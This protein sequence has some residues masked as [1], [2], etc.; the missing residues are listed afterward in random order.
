MPPI[1]RSYY[2]RVLPHYLMA[3]EITLPKNSEEPILDKMQETWMGHLQGAK[4]QYR[5]GKLH[6]RE[7]D[8]HYTIHKDAADPRKDP[9]G[10]IIHD[11]PEVLAGM[12]G[13]ALGMYAGYMLGKKTDSKLTGVAAGAILTPVLFKVC[14]D[15]VASLKGR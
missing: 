4:R 2:N 14:M 6:I 15:T 10:H 11:A 13:G 12:V 1:K 8:T 5:H 9:I 3:I 7:Y